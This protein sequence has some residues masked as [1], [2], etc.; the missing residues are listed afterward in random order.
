M[1]IYIPASY[2]ET[3]GARALADSLID[4]VYGFEEQWP[5]KFAVATSVEDVL[6]H[7]ERGRS[8]L[9]VGLENGTGIE[10]DPA[11]LQHFYDR[12]IRYVTLT[13]SAD[14][15]IGDSSY[16]TTRSHGGLTE[17]GREVVRE[18][19]RLGI[20]V[21]ISHVSDDTFYDVLDVTEVPPIASHSSA[22]HFT[23][24]FER[25]MSDDMIRARSEARGIIMI[26][27]GSS[28]ISEDYRTRRAAATEEIAAYF[29]ENP[30]LTQDERRDYFKDYMRENVGYADI[31][32]V[33]AHFDHEIDLVGVD[34]VVLWSYYYGVIEPLPTD[35]K[36]V[37]QGARRG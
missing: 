19:N 33:L 36:S 16:D 8:P 23:P 6:D 31:D 18:M 4:M 28:F 13:H 34:Y 10:D 25:N 21:D 24:G 11:T 12:G 9:P 37:V 32:D 29:E 15:L 30:D 26:N 17:F 35:R 3:G 7:F 1:S 22:R 20:M 5:D 27:Y 14:N 2:E